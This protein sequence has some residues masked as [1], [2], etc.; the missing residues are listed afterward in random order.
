LAGNSCDRNEGLGAAWTYGGVNSLTMWM[1]GTPTV[2][3]HHYLLTISL[4]DDK[5]AYVQSYN[6]KTHWAAFSVAAISLNPPTHGAQLSS[7][8]IL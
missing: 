1:N 5:D 3:G 7:V 4:S 2:K 6:E 8:V